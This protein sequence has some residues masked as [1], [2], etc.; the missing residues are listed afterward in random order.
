MTGIVPVTGTIFAMIALGYASV[1]FGLFDAGAMRVLGRYVVNLALPALIFRAVTANDLGAILDA[2]YL[3]AYLFGSI[4]TFGL[5]YAWSRRVT[6]LS[7]LASTFQG[8]GM[9]CAN[10]GFVGY[11]ILLMTL[12]AVAG[13]ALALNM[14][15][16]NLVMIP[17]I[18]VM[19]E[20]ARGVADTGGVLAWRILRRLAANPI[21]LGLLAGLAVAASGVV[22]PTIVSRS[23]DLVAQSSAAISL[24]VIGGALVGLPPG[25][26]NRAV[27]PVVAGKLAVHPIAVGLGLAAVPY[28]FAVEVEGSLIAAGIV[29]AAMPPMGIYPIIAQQY[30]E[31]PVA[32]MAMLV[33]TALSF[34]TVSAVLWGLSLGAS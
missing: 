9:S 27:A 8:M 32:A 7:P 26:I 24:I 22:L 25:G 21:I 13:T 2:G 4:A 10:S 28:L 6:R 34:F 15:V 29:V 3:V 33:M 20:R 23:V 19:A 5:G 17:L 16:E 14:V 30:G 31:G 1:R 11:P 18:L 12:P